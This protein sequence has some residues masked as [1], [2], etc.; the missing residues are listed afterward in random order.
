MLVSL[1]QTIGPN[2]GSKVATPGLGFAYA[3]TLGGYLSSVEPGERARSSISPLMV[4]ENG[5]P[6]LV[7]GAAG[8][9]R[10][11]SAVVQ[12]ICRFV[13][14]GL[15]LPEALAA[16][17]VHPMDGGLSMETSP[18]IGW[19]DAVVDSVESWGFEVREVEAAGAFGRIH[20]IFFDPETGHAVG[21]ADP[22]W[23]GAAIVPEIP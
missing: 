9:A 5:E 23:E 10:I 20:G 13:D 16:A 19:S 3:A 6:R 4:L 22:D 18:G 14:Q 12:A 2:L 11:V 7:L 21:V 1:T 17:R 8:G 15:A